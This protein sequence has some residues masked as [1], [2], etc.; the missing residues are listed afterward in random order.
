MRPWRLRTTTVRLELTERVRQTSSASPNAGS[1]AYIAQRW[2]STDTLI[3]T[4]SSTAVAIDLA[5]TV[6]VVRLF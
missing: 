4:S 1:P 2:R 6:V 5:T 3:P